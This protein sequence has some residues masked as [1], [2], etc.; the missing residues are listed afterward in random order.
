M[1]DLSFSELAIIGSV[2]L[3]V[4]GPEKLP[5][6]AKTAGSWLGKAQRMVQQVKSDIERETELSELKKIQDE[7]K[8]IADN[9]TQTI[10]GEAGLL[11]KEFSSITSDVNRSASEIEKKAGEIGASAEQAVSPVSADTP[12]E[13]GP[14][15]D[16][17]QSS[18]TQTA[19]TAS[20]SDDA[21]D[22]SGA[23]IVSSSEDDPG[24]EDGYDYSWDEDSEYTYASEPQGKVFAKR[25]KSGPSIDELADQLERLKTEIGDRSPKFGGNNRRYVVRARTNRVRIYR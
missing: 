14:A 2:A 13:V 9:L 12:T 17:A 3:V 5:M 20:V 15:S 22:E 16:A 21:E 19:G 10:K 8:G 4:L 24:S 6:V 1:I 23:Q 25:Y 11:E 18:E 7:A